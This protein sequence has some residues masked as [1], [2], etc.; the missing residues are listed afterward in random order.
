MSNCVSNIYYKLILH[1]HLEATYLR[2]GDK[3]EWNSA[4]E[5]SL[6]HEVKCR[7]GIGLNTVSQSVKSKRRILYT[8]AKIIYD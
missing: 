7:C 3:L 1:Q 8:A 4:A 6:S 2:L 5:D